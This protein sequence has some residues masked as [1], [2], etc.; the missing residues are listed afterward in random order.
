[1][2]GILTGARDIHIVIGA[3]D[4]GTWDVDF[5]DGTCLQVYAQCNQNPGQSFSIYSF[6][7]VVQQDWEY[8]NVILLQSIFIDSPLG[9]FDSFPNLTNGCQG[10]QVPQCIIVSPEFLFG[11]SGGFTSIRGPGTTNCLGVVE[12]CSGGSDSYPFAVDFASDPTHV[13]AVWTRQPVP[14]PSP[15]ALLGIGIVGLGAAKLRRSN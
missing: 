1:M 12:T 7:S 11:G 14:E 9:M 8:A 4:R 3:I 2:H 15:L 13:W 6:R 10:S 5:V